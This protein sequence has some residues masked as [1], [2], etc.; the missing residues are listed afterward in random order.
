MIREQFSDQQLQILTRVIVYC[1]CTYELRTKRVSCRSRH[2]GSR[3]NG[4]HQ[5][6]A[7]HRASISVLVTSTRREIPRVLGRFGGINVA[8]TVVEFEVAGRAEGEYNA[9]SVQQHVRKGHE[10]ESS[11]HPC[12]CRRSFRKS[13]LLAVQARSSPLRPQIADCGMQ[14]DT[15][16]EVGRHYASSLSNRRS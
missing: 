10:K 15:P 3:H 14:I 6:R 8:L 4:P 5:V 1:V 11:S 16:E 9:T 13:E 7:S 2:N 12:D